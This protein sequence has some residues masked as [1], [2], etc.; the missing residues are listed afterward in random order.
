MTDS[1]PKAIVIGCGSHF[2]ADDAAGLQ[3]LETLKAG[4]PV[5]G[6]EYRSYDGGWPPGFIAEIP[7]DTV[8]LFIAAAQRGAAPGTICCVKLPSKS[9]HCDHLQSKGPEP[10]TLEDELQLARKANGAAP[11]VFLVGIDSAQHRG[12]GTGLS[13]R[14][15]AAVD[16]IV[17]NFPRYLK[18]AYDL[19]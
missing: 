15:Q 6:C 12:A 3:V 9:V 2:T 14:V 11:R 1:V 4:S 10:I 5:E 13:E 16:E 7:V 8:I 18:L 17:R 19:A